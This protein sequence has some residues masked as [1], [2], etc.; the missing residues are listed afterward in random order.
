MNMKPLKRF[1]KP[2]KKGRT[3]ERFF[4]PGLIEFL[5]AKLL[6]NKQLTPKTRP[7]TTKGDMI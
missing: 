6:N 1:K 3:I 7:N 4:R 2:G 5:K